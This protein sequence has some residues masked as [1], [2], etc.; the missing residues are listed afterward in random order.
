MNTSTA[1][2]SPDTDVAGPPARSTVSKVT[3]RLIPFMFVLY[4]ANYIDRV[5]VSFAAHGMSADLG[6]T[7]TAYGFGAGIFFLGY[8]LFQ[9]PANLILVRVGARRWIGTIIVAWGL[10]AGA[11]A[12]VRTPVEFY[13]LRVLLGFAEA[14]FFPGMIMYLTLWFP[15]SERARSVSRF[16]TAI[17]IAGIVGGPLAGALLSLD[18]TLGIAGW[19]WLLFLEAVPSVLLGVVAFRYLTD[20]PA[21]AAWLEAEERAWLDGELRR[22][23][24]AVTQRYAASPLRTLASG[25]VWALSLLWLLMVLPYYGTTLWMPQLIREH[26]NPSDLVLGLLAAIPPLA[27]CT[28]MIA[29]GA[30]SDRRHERFLHI[31]LPQLACAVGLG[32][33]AVSWSLPVTILGLSLAAAGANGIC[34]PYWGLPPRF[35]SGAA[36]A[37]AI[38]LINMVGSIGGFAGPYALGAVKDRTHGFGPALLGLAAMALGASVLVLL[39]RRAPL[40]K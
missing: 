22:E 13:V 40:L 6:L 3:R 33:L 17:P 12:F 26:A 31:A 2:P 19:R 18:G 16:M 38:G 35:L 1:E 14:G 8:I 15:A 32:L 23:H 28:A 21:D 30:S 11:M 9:I 34:G 25:T 7:G 4:V 37:S 39:L 29:I 27:G 24:E 20:R 36:A 10:V 5:N